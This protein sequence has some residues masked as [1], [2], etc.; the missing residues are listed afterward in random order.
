MTYMVSTSF[1]AFAELCERLEATRS[2]NE[3]VQQISSFISTLQPDEVPIAV[4]FLTGRVF[5]EQ[6]I[7]KL[8][9]G[10]ATLWK[11]AKADSLQVTLLPTETGLSLLDLNRALESLASLSGTDRQQ[12][13]ENILQGLFSRFGGLEKRYGFRLLSGEMEIGAV[14]GVLLAAIAAASKL[15]LNKVRRA[16]MTMGDIGHIAELALTNPSAVGSARIVMFNPVR[17]MLAEMATSI[18]QILESHKGGTAF[19]YKY[20]GARIQIHKHGAEVRIFS[21]RLSDVTLSIP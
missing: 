14:D 15:D 19:E 2:R 10:G 1:L 18:R 11:L 4:R 9:V 20:D 7:R 3:K 13:A 8:G 16:Y 6:E 5:G 12:R 21:R 17:P